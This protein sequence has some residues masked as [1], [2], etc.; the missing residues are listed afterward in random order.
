MLPAGRP[1]LI[2]LLQDYRELYSILGNNAPPL[3]MG[4]T[5]PKLT[6]RRAGKS[7]ATKW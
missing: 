3:A 7:P 4:T 6:E 2:R 1:P 5:L